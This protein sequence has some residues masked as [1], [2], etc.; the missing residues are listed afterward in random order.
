M[1]AVRIHEAGGPETLIYED[2]PDPL[3]G[4]GEVLVRV[5]ACALNHL[6][7]WATLRRPGTVFPRPRILGADVSGVVESVGEGV[8]GIDIGMP[9][10][11]QP[12][13]SC[14]V[15]QRCLEGRDS[16]CPS[17]RI[18]GHGYDVDGG[19]AE[20]VK[21]PQAN[22][23]PKPPNLSFEEAAAIPLTFLTAWHML[24]TRAQVRPGEDVL[25]NAVGS[26]VG[27]AALQIARLFGA[28]VIASAGS[29]HKLAKARALGAADTINYN[30][31]DLAQAVLSLTG[32]RGVDLVFE[33]VGD[34]VL[35]K[36]LEALTKGGRLVTCGTTG[37]GQVSVDVTRLFLREQSILGAY[38]G[39]KGELLQLLPFFADGRLKAVIDRV[40]PL[41]QVQEAVRHLAGRE[42][43]GKVVLV[44][45]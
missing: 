33:S 1:K 20:L 37:G 4:P 29:D 25:V 17:Y 24:V 9:V 21:L 22:V 5:R 43:F 40:Y 12:G 45:G 26:G 39:S 6:E 28:T 3:P 8:A 32:G 36:S 23:A 30:T 2:A 41:P 11:I 16:H 35:L 34:D 14:G 31:Q 10:V 19:L 18:L 13:L 15:C 42:N 38:M 27:V 7:V 44:P